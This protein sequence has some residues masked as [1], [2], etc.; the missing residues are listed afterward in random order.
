MLERR[1]SIKKIAIG[2]AQFGLDYGISNL[3]GKTEHDEVSRI[4]QYCV[5]NGIN[6]LDTAFA[7]GE[8]EVVLGRNELSSFAVVSKFLPPNSSTPSITQQFQASLNRLNL[9][10][11]YGY[12]S[13]R[14]L[15]V[16]MEDWNILQNYKSEGKIKK[17]GF[18][19]NEPEEVDAVL[20][21]GFIPDL[22]Q[23]P[24]NF[25]DNRFRK[26]LMYL[27]NK[28]N[29]EIHT[30]SVFL[31]GLF[32]VNPDELSDFFN[33]IKSELKRIF[34]IE[35]KAGALIGYALSQCF[36][37]K[38]V[39]GVN[40]VNQLRENIAQIQIAKK[41]EPINILQDNFECVTPSKWPKS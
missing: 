19:F 18:S 11:L 24:F 2:T 7:Y 28:Y 36:I 20:E 9:P 5:G 12:L 6:T 38:V 35:N 23:A 14:A 25:L 13:H 21:K 10:R 31:Q 37:D 3:S 41:I 30:R 1:L 34:K 39:I 32:F 27:K 22:V 8:S 29:T 16:S 4:L 17:T 33:P 40:N 26:K 15:N